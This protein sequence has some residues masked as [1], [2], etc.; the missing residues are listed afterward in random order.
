MQKLLKVAVVLQNCSYL[1]LEIK[2]AEK[3]QIF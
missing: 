3:Y 2:R 1:V